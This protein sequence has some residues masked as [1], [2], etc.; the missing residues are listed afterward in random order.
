MLA[1]NQHND[2]LRFNADIIDNQSTEVVNMKQVTVLRLK[3]FTSYQFR[4]VAEVGEGDLKHPLAYS[5][6]SLGVSTKPEGPPSTPPMI[7]SVQRLPNMNINI[8]FLPPEFPNGK[9]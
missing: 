7:L 9:M 1:V 8:T 2:N 5:A 6:P 3:P 4:L